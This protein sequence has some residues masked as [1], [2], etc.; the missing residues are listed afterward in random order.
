[1]TLVQTLPSFY[2]TL[3]R[4]TGPCGAF[5]W[6]GLST[7]LHQINTICMIKCYWLY[8]NAIWVNWPF[9]ALE[10]KRSQT[11]RESGLG[12][13]LF[14][15]RHSRKSTGVNRQQMMAGSH[16]AADRV[17]VVSLSHFHVLVRHSQCSN[18]HPY[19]DK[20]KC[21]KSDALVQMT[22]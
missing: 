6:W 5:C 3:H 11:Q 8:V 12:V 15:T 13:R 7:V 2:L 4:I 19:Y 16:L 10:K 18:R 14:M 21:L 17:H 1:M 22:N 9:N 20:K